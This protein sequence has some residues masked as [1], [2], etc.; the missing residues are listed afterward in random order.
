MAFV[1][2]RG[3]TKGIPRKNIKPLQGKPLISY[4]IEYAKKSKYINK[5]VVSTGDKK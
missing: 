4:S 5:V 3:G 1:P 2:A